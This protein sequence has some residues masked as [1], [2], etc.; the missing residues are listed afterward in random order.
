MTNS[1]LKLCIALLSLTLTSCSSSK[2]L[3]QKHNTESE[4]YQH[5]IEEAMSPAPSKIDNNLIAITKNNKDL[6]WKTFWDKDYLLVVAWKEDS[7]YY[8]INSDSG[9]YNNGS[10]KL[11]VSTAPQLLNKMKEPGSIDTTLRLQQLIGLPP[12]ANYK[13]F[14]E[15]WVRPKDL[16]RPCPDAEITDTYCGLCFPKDT[17]SSYKSWINE[18][19][20][21]SYYNCELYQ[22]YPWTQLGYTYDWNPNLDSPVGLSEFIIKDSSNVFIKDIYT[23]REYLN[24]DE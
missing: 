6:I 19:R 4:A 3:S 5:A 11:W 12:T 9:F 10:H 14:I 18:M 20:L 1:S 24:K 23:T 21:S 15:F 17:D 8:K 16:F 7:S 2:N 22:K 13:Y